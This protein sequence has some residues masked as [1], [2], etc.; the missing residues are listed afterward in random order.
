MILVACK[1][2]F[3]VEELKEQ[4]SKELKI[5]GMQ[6]VRDIT[7][8]LLY[9]SQRRYIEKVLKEVLQ[10]HRQSCFYS[11]WFSLLIL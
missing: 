2:M 11:T 3:E 9:L 5:L 4:L 1:R 6:I 10:G 7:N 8:G